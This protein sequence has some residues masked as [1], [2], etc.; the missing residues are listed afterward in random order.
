MKNL[1]SFYAFGFLAL[2][3]VEVWRPALL[4]AAVVAFT[5]MLRSVR[6]R[7]AAAS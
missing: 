5:A 7:Q 3:G 6:H 4:L 2:T 1:W